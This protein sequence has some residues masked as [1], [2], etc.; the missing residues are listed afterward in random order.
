MKIRAGGY[1][2]IFVL[3]FVTLF[4]S[5]S[6]KERRLKILMNCGYIVCGFQFLIKEVLFMYYVANMHFFG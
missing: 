6:Q 1:L 5:L 3:Q 2:F 4:I